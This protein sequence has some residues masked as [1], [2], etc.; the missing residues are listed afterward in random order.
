MPFK[1]KFFF[2]FRT[3]V[4]SLLK[5]CKTT[6]PRRHKLTSQSDAP[7]DQLRLLLPLGQ[8]TLHKKS[9][10]V[11]RSRKDLAKT[12]WSLGEV[13]EAKRLR[14]MLIMGLTPTAGYYGRRNLDTPSPPAEN[15]ELWNVL[16][17]W[18]KIGQNVAFH[19]SP[20]ARSSAFCYFCLPRSFNSYFPIL[21][22]QKL[23]LE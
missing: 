3:S 9:C 14:T 7:Y 2:T 13:V 19:A 15:P 11:L 23:C 8:A 6:G 5:Q 4:K 16:S 10:D 20:N 17:L 21:F 22:K 18:L 12:S 1:K